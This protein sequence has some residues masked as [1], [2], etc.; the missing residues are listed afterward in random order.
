MGPLRFMT[1]GN[2]SAGDFSAPLRFARND[3]E[4]WHYS[5]V[6]RQGTVRHKISPLPSK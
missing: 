1:A 2:D 5:D 4:V 6:R 3:G